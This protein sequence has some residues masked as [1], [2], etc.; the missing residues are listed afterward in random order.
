MKSLSALNAVFS[1]CSL[2]SLI[3][4]CVAWLTSAS[5]LI[6]TLEFLPTMILSTWPRSSNPI[7]LMSS[8]V[9]SEKYL[10]FTAN[11]MS[12]ISS[13]LLYP[14][15]G[16]VML[17]NFKLFL[18]TFAA[19]VL[20][21]LV[22][23]GAISNSFLFCCIIGLSTFSICKILFISW[24]HTSTITSSSIHSSLRWLFKNRFDVYPRSTLIPLVTSA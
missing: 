23:Q 2:S 20:M 8:P 22:E 18:T 14:N 9:F 10:A 24:S 5:F 7:K 11:A 6:N 4:S 1:C 3:R 13:W 12:C 19:S 21:T 16:G 17:H 15:C